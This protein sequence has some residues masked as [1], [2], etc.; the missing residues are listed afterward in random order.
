MA[1]VTT[2]GSLSASNLSTASA[3]TG[4][5]YNLGNTIGTVVYADGKTFVFSGI[6]AFDGNGNLT[7]N[8]LANVSISEGGVATTQ[9][10]GINTLPQATQTLVDAGNQAGFISFYLNG[11][12]TITGSVGANALDGFAGNDAIT[13]G[14]GSDIIDGGEGNDILFGGEGLVS[15]ADGNDVIT[16]GLGLDSLYG[17]AGNDVIFGGTGAV[18]P[19]DVSNEFLHGG[20]GNDSLF[21]NGGDDSLY[22]G[23]GQDAVFGGDGNDLL[24]GGW[25]QF[26]PT[27]TADSL[28]GGNGNDSVFGNGGDD[29]LSGGNGDD[30]LHGGAGNDSFVMDFATSG[31]DRIFQ[32]DNPGTSLGDLLVFR[33]TSNTINTDANTILSLITYVDGNATIDFTILGSALD[34]V[35]NNVAVGSITVGDITFV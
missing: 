16:G 1:I 8:N 33:D 11:A 18:S 34:V 24:Y 20:I 4:G 30:V 9:I 27:D 13:G 12:D 21:G 31:V 15:T 35:I 26:D 2:T 17:N 5:G 28:V 25:Q 32:F 7:G 23:E 3:I 29:F 22:G 10:D 6:F 14:L 19:T